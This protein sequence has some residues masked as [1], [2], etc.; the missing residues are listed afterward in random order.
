VTG[1]LGTLRALV[2]APLWW[3]AKLLPLVAAA[4]LAALTAGVDAADG[5]PR[6]AAML[7]AAVSVAAAAHVVND[8]ADLASDRAAGKES[9]AARTSVGGRAGLLTLCALGAILPWFVVPLDIVAASILGVLVV[10]SAIYSLPPIRLKGRATAG[11]AADALVAHTLPTAFAF[12]ELGSAGVRAAWWWV[13]LACSLV[14]STAFGVRSIVVHQILDSDGDTAAGVATMVVA[15]GVPRAARLGRD[16]SA[17]E[18][19]ALAGLLVV[20][21]RV[22]PWL[23][24]AFVAHF[25]MWAHH[26]RFDA[27]PIDMVPTSP[28]AWLPLAEFYEV[29]PAIGFG[30]VLASREPGWWWIVGTVVAVFASAVLKQAASFAAQL[31]ELAHEIVAWFRR[32]VGMKPVWALYRTYWS[33]RRAV[34]QPL[35]RAVVD[36]LRALVRRNGRRLRR[37]L[38]GGRRRRPDGPPLGGSP[39]SAP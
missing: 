7:V 8:L 3:T 20:S 32:K 10:V 36:P 14:W 28:G 33:V 37:R 39:D 16:A 6:I 12:V 38:P 15:K 35:R 30:L 23:G 34:F 26:R 1:P 17:V 2:R 27:P 9:S 11:V 31:R 29:W 4:E 25:A 24:L 5:V 21:F 22:N 18:V 19:V 13:A